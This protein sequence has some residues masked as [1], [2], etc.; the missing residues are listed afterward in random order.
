MLKLFSNNCVV[1]AMLLPVS[2]SYLKT[3]SNLNNIVRIFSNPYLRDKIAFSTHFV[4]YKAHFEDYQKLDELGFKIVLFMDKTD[5]IVDYGNLKFDFE[6]YVTKEF[7]EHN[8]KFMDFAQKGEIKY[9]IIDNINKYN[10]DELIN[11]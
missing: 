6:F 1:P 3:K 9:D 10:E 7:L 4:D 11:V 2:S 8:P 5:I